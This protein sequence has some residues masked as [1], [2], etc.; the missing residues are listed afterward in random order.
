MCVAVAVS[1]SLC[2][3][4]LRY[5]MIILMLLINYKVL[6]ERC[7]KNHK[8]DKT[9]KDDQK[10]REERKKHGKN[11][12]LHKI[13]STIRSIF[14]VFVLATLTIKSIIIIIYN[15]LHIISFMVLNIKNI[16][17]ILAGARG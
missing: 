6:N 1:S 7:T 2:F 9:V 16:F 8:K 11:F 12:K 13:Y 3:A 14:C 5:G 10:K 17:G 15:N 4:L